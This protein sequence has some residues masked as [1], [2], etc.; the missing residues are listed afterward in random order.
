MLKT[1]SA[2]LT[3]KNLNSSIKVIEHN[4]KFSPESGEEL[5]I[6]YDIIVDASDNPQVIFYV[7]SIYYH[8]YF[9]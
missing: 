7:H 6:L 3:M 2:A 8:Q 9:M 1:K 5:V 4:V